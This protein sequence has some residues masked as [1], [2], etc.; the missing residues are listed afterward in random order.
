[1]KNDLFLF[2]EWYKAHRHVGAWPSLSEFKKL[3]KAYSE[4]GRFYHT[5][6]H[7]AECIRFVNRN[8]GS[9]SDA[10]L[11]KF[12]LFYHDIFYDVN[13]KDNEE[14]SAQAW[15]E[16]SKASGLNGK[17]LLG[18]HKVADLIRMTAAHKVEANASLIYKMMSD[19]DMHIFLCPDHHYLDYAK[20][21]WREYQGF[22]K[23]AYLKGRQAFL[24]TVDPKSMFYTHQARQLVHHA[25]ANLDLERTILR[26]K[27]EEIL[28]SG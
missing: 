3:K 18:S 7:I 27:P 12:A 14:L 8:Y 24:D 22:G 19:A 11:V 1:M 9:G 6:Q 16:Y 23:E 25:I 20:N 26:D 15:E 21:V 5:F 4:P 2:W 17:L 10:V 13:R 28:N